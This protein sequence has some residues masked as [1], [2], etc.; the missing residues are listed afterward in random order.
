MACSYPDTPCAC[1]SFCRKSFAD[2]ELCLLNKYE[3]AIIKTVRRRQWSIYDKIP[4]RLPDL[5]IGAKLC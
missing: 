1:E 3:F 2:T 4:I 5:A